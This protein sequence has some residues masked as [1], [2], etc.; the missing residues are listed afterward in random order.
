V[1]TRIIQIGD[2]QAIVDSDMY[3]TLSALRWRIHRTGNDKS[4][5]TPMTWTEF[6]GKAGAV[7][8]HR[9]IMGLSDG[10]EIDHINR[11][12]LDNRRANLR[13]CTR[14]ENARNRTYRKASGG[15]KGVSPDGTR[16]RA[17]IIL[18]GKHV[19]LGGYATEIEGAVAYDAAA[20]EHYG[21]FACL[22]FSP[23]RDWI[24]PAP[25]PTQRTLT[26]RARREAA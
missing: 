14:R 17:Y 7:S 20:R 6:N 24:L 2:D 16:W 9:L 15:Y 26:Y 1:V 25:T 13:F 8:M 23:D 19:S 21:E 11:N 10:L 18:D 5:K 4:H 22:N 3:E 12:P